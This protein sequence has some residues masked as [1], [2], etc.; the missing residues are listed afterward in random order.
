MPPS[1]RTAVPSL[2]RR[3]LPV[4]A[5]LVAL[6]LVMTGLVDHARSAL[7]LPAGRSARSASAARAAADVRAAGVSGTV[8]AI[9]GVRHRARGHSRFAGLQADTATVVAAK[10][11]PS[12][13]GSANGPNRLR[14][15]DVLVVAQRSLPAGLVARLRRLG[16]VAAAVPVDAGRVR[17]NGVFVNVLGVDPAAFRPF[18]A[19]P[20]ARS[21]A[22]WANVS[23]GEIAISFTM[24]SQ[25]RL[26]LAA[27]VRVSG[28]RTLTLPVAGFGT[29]GIGDVDAMVSDQVARQLGL[30]AGNAIVISAPHARLAGLMTKLKKLVPA[31]AAVAALVTQVV[32]GGR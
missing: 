18:A 12:A 6:F 1:G 17:V 10:P 21:D 8:G 4:V 31:H 29:A 30:P 28:A 15:A 9:P 25:D 32:T 22:L 11:L 7:T 16:G 3:L 27:P 23:A 24:G 5:L 19:R 13:H 20:T 26:N 14:Q 2:A